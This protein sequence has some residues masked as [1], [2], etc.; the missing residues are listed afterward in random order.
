ME[1]DG[2]R[3]F[4]E[5][6][7][8][9][10][11]QEAE[12]IRRETLAAAYDTGPLDQSAPPHITTPQPVNEPTPSYDTPLPAELDFDTT[13]LIPKP[14]NKRTLNMR[15][16]VREIRVDLFLTGEPIFEKNGVKVSSDRDFLED[17]L[18]GDDEVILGLARGDSSLQFSRNGVT[19]TTGSGEEAVTRTLSYDDLKG[20]DL[21][22]VNAS[23]KGAGQLFLP[24]IE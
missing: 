4:D 11:R 5:R 9:G 22:M 12:R 2:E 3:K 18:E 15:H 14:E 13:E 17:G 24:E 16:K 21:R 10:R 20:P 6:A 1:G 7:L 8:E 19:I 23:L